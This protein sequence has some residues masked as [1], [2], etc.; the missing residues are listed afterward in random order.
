MQINVICIK[1]VYFL[2]FSVGVEYALHCLTYFVDLPSGTTIRTKELA[3]FQGVSETY[4]SKIFTKLK[5]AGIVRSM[6][7]VKG[8]YELAKHPSKI[9]FWDVVE[10][11]E[12]TQPFFQCTQIRE[13]CVLLQGKEV[14]ESI[15]CSPC[16][17]NVIMLEAEEKMKEYLKSK[18]IA[19]L[20]ETI[21]F[22]IKDIHEEGVL[23]FREAL[24]RR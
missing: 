6:P 7:G 8:G 5:K 21:K 4:L 22:K 2:Q 24:D 12:G 18:T 11:I 14:P 13:N 23:W 19:S 15:S 1:G 17:I 16:T 9:N 3:T 20:N 10:A